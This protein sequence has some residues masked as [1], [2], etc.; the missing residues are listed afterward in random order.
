MKPAHKERLRL[1]HQA[2]LDLAIEIEIEKYYATDELDYVV[3]NA[4]AKFGITV[5]RVLRALQRRAEYAGKIFD[6]EPYVQVGL[7][8]YL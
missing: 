7:G 1:L 5:T 8:K 2:R 3:R 6:S 4:A